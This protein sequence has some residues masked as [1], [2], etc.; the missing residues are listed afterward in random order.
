MNSEDLG[1]ISKLSPAPG[2]ESDCLAI[3]HTGGPFV[4]K[5]SAF[6]CSFHAELWRR[7]LWM[8]SQTHHSSAPKLMGNSRCDFVTACQRISR[9]PGCRRTRSSTPLSAK[10]HKHHQKKPR[11]EASLVLSARRWCTQRALKLSRNW[12]KT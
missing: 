4:N 5:K 3:G 2:P 10:L 9:H 7:H 8:R 1:S 6:I 12:M 11:N